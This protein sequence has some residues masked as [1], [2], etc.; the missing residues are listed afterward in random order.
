[1][2]ENSGKKAYVFGF[3]IVISEIFTKTTTWG[4]YLDAVAACLKVFFTELKVC[5][6]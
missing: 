4:N 6:T 3:E 2:T 1:M 5:V